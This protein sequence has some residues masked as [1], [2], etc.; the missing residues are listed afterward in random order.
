MEEK[1]LKAKDIPGGYALCF[2]SDCEKKETC[3]HYLAKQLKGCERNIG[4][5]VYPSAWQDGK[6]SCYKEKKLVQNAWGFS[7]L[8]CNL[9]SYLR[10]EARRSVSALFG[11]GNGQYYRAHHG[12]IMVSPK[13]Q[14]EIKE[15]LAKFGNNDVQFDHYVTEWDFD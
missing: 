2:N 14:E 15:V 4:Q 3:M 5:A 7:Q 1:E 9:P 6:C 8:Y 10:A 13:R 12:W 11:S